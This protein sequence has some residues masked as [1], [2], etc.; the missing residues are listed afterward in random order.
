MSREA[1]NIIIIIIMVI[2]G[3]VSVCGLFGSCSIWCGFSRRL[4][5]IMRV[6]RE[7][8]R[9]PWLLLGEAINNI[10]IIIIIVG[11]VIIIIFDFIVGFIFSIFS[12]G[13]V[14]GGRN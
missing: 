3:A 5:G 13:G 4:C 12:G 1:I 8:K 11:A 6:G 7:R 10:V 14:R 2:V 9:I